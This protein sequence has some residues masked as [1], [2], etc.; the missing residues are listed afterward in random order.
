MK[1]SR[2]HFSQLQ[3]FI[4]LSARRRRREKPYERGIVF[5]SFYYQRLHW[6][7][8]AQLKWQPLGGVRTGARHA[9]GRLGGLGS[10]HVLEGVPAAR[11]RGGFIQN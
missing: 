6:L 1:T 10:E 5:K 7:L 11:G 4:S 9:D 8:K 3:T 2:D